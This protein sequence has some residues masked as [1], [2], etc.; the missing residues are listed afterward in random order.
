MQRGIAEQHVQQL[1]RIVADGRR[2]E[3]DTNGERAVAE[4]VDRL[5]LA[6]DLGQHRRLVDRGQRHFHALFHRDRLR[7]GL[8]RGGVA[9]H[10]IGDGKAFGHDTGIT[11]RID[12]DGAVRAKDHRVDIDRLQPIAKRNGGGLQRQQQVDESRRSRPDVSS[13][14]LVQDAAES[15]VRATVVRSLRGRSG[16][17]TW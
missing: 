8:D 2:R 14:G 15:A 16:S 6:D 1:S 13:D 10:V 5:D 7:A 17:A 9:A 11:K 3:T 12:R 4:I